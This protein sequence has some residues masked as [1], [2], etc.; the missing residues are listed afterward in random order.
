M[1]WDTNIISFMNGLDIPY[2]CKTTQKSRK[3]RFLIH[4]HYILIAFTYMAPFSI[5]VDCNSFLLIKI[6]FELNL[7][8]MHFTRIK[9]YS[10]KVSSNI[11][12]YCLTQLIL[13]II[14]KFL[15]KLL[16]SWNESTIPLMN[17]RWIM[18]ITKG[19]RH[20]L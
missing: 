11:K 7:H 20:S 18:K 3:M 9:E 8:R 10:Y 13:L 15:F 2:W 19:Q 14:S 16:L 1:K 17:H 12:L 5:A 4:V 6:L